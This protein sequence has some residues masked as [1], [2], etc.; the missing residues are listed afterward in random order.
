[1]DQKL[2]ER[3]RNQ[4]YAIGGKLLNSK[5]FSWHRCTKMDIEG[6]EQKALEG[7]KNIIRAYRPKLAIS[8]Y[9]KADDFYKIPLCI[10]ELVPEYQFY[11]RHYICFYADTVLYAVCR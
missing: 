3:L 7:A 2:S 10:H 1:M 9:H 5:Y 6:A 8:I 4:G 11:V